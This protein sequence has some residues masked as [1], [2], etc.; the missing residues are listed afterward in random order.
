MRLPE[1]RTV[2][3][4]ADLIAC[5]GLFD[6]LEDRAAVDLLALLW[7]RLEPGGVL[8]AGNFAPGHPTR[9]YMEWVG[10]WYLI[11]RTADDLHRLAHQAE[12]GADA[13]R[14]AAERTGIDL[15]LV[16]ERP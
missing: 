6:Y 7:R 1:R 9:S 14:V 4:T 16:V 13:R 11:Y 3:P 15:F 2:L 10:N 12:I 8:L 5:P